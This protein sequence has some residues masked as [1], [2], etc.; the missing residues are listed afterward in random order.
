MSRKLTDPLAGTSNSSRWRAGNPARLE[1]LR[2]KKVRQRARREAA[3]QLARDPA[4]RFKG[5]G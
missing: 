3:K 1:K 2:L 4:G 5:N